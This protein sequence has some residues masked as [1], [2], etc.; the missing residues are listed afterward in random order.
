MGYGSRKPE[1]M[2]EMFRFSCSCPCGDY[3]SSFKSKQSLLQIHMD[4][5]VNTGIEKVLHSNAHF[6]LQDLFYIVMLTLG[7]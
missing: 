7:L 3:F 1:L 4:V 2:T 6:S 5:Y